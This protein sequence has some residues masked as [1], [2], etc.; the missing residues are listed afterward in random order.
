MSVRYLCAA[1]VPAVGVDGAALWLAGDV[2]RRLLV[3]TTDQV[4]ATLDEAQFTLGEGPCVQAWEDRRMVLAADMGSADSGTRWPMFTPAALSAGAAAVFAFPLQVG[5]IRVGMLDLYRRLPGPLSGDQLADALAFA[6][7]ALTLALDQ[8][9]AEPDEA[10]AVRA[11]TPGLGQ[12]WPLS[13]PA[14]GRVEV[15][16]A[17]GMVAIQL[18]TGLEEALLR[19]RAHAFAHGMGVGE[20]ARLVVARRLRLGPDD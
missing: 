10:R 12:G 19:M 18:G 1:C 16:Q 3:H 5:A 4:A 15:Y 17:T 14:A 7:A 6:F 13:G 20:V 2:R 9:R 11:G 8:T